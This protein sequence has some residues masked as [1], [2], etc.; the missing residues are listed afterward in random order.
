MLFRSESVSE[1]VTIGRAQPRLRGSTHDFDLAQLDPE[2]LGQVGGP[3][4]RRV[5]DDQHVRR[6]ARST[7]T[8]KHLFDVRRFFVCRENDQSTHRREL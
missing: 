2:L 3:V 1:P 4:R 6:R 5:V 8:T 7:K